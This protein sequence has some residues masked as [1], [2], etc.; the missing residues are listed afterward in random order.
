MAAQT[1]GLLIDGDA[2]GKDGGLR[3]D[4]AL[5]D[6]RAGEHLAQLVLEPGAVFRQRDGAALLDAADKA[7]DG[8][9][10]GAEVGSHGRALRLAHGLIDGDGLRRNG[11]QVGKILLFVLLRLLHHEDVGQRGERGSADI[12]LHAVICD[13]GT[14]GAQ[15]PLEHGAVQRNGS[16]LRARRVHADEHVHLAALDGVLYKLFDRILRVGERA[17]QAHGAIE[18]AIVDG[19]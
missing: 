14:H 3:Q 1:D 9:R 12:V 17:G 7:A 19:A 11:G 4:A 13:H 16:L 8:L 5:V 10:A 2:V 18:E 6:R 15:I